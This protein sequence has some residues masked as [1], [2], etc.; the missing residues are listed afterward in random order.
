MREWELKLAGGR[1]VIWNGTSGED[2]AQRY[3]ASHPTAV[4]IATRNYPRTGLFVGG[5]GMRIIG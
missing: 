5:R 1:T 3:A 2:A 4:V